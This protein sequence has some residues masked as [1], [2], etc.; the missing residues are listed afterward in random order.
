MNFHRAATLCRGQSSRLLANAATSSSSRLFSAAPA[1]TA[2]ATAAATT[3]PPSIPRVGAATAF[4]NEYPGQNYIFNWCLN[5]D[6]V[7]PLQKCAF[8]ITK[9]LDLKVAGLALP[10]SSPLNVNAKSDRS[11]VPEAGMTEALSFDTFDEV[12]QRT[13]DA[14]SLSEA[15]YCP[16]GHAP[17][18]KFGVRVITNSG[19]EDTLVSD[20]MAYLE[21]MPKRDP[22]SQ[23][24]TCYVL[25]GPSCEEFA[26]Y[27]IEEV[28]E[29]T[30]D[31]SRE[32][33][34]VATVVITGKKPSLKRVVAGIELSVEGLEADAVERAE[35]KAEEEKGE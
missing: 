30:E 28:E 20:L 6:G 18:T 11:K 27:A 15:L 32:A 2:A 13:K 26:G 8:R 4:P 14:L 33:I 1:A 23:S 25:G 29:Q 19:K 22:T 12:T 16:E 10:K 9:P 34:S 24:V 21:R 17:N 7:T 35:K 5:A 3:L 31:G